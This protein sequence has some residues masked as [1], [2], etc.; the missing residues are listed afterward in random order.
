MIIISLVNIISIRTHII[1][2]IIGINFTVELILRYIIIII[3]VRYLLLDYIIVCA[4]SVTLFN[5][6]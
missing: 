2:K 3:F 5:L 6:S 4:L 1:N